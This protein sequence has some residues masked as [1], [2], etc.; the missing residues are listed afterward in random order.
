MRYI[1][2]PVKTS[3]WKPGYDWLVDIVQRV[4][5]I[6]EDDDFF[7]I[8]EKAISVATGR[9]IDEK[10]VIP[11]FIARLIAI[12]WMRVV[13]GRLLGHLCH[14][15]QTNIQRL[16]RYPIEEGAAHKQLAINQVGLLQA[17]RHG[18]EGGID[19]SNLP[20]SLVALPL[21][22]PMKE[23][24]RIRERLSVETGKKPI[25]L[26]VDSDKT[27][28]FHGFHMSARPTSVRAIKCLGL[29]GYTLGRLLKLVARST[30]VALVGQNLSVEEVLQI[31]A[32]ANKVR[33]SG[34]GRTA[35]DM[36][37]TFHVK[38][39]EVTWKMLETVRHT[40]IVIVRRVSSDRITV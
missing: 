13:W 27:Y 4:P 35:W 8:S 20:F 34:A 23:A 40:P 22:D 24:T 39:H 3:Y 9:V 16:R 15:S 33:G 26:I 7:V 6:V 31:S 2:R 17:L 10:N 37:E 28:S 32:V 25:V 29:F 1:A 14:L 12:G 18:S 19:T 30:P 38:P 5:K 11:T 36:G 21:L